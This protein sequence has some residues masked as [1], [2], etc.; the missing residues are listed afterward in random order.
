MDWSSKIKSWIKESE[1]SAFDKSLLLKQKRREAVRR[2][3]VFAISRSSVRMQ[4]YGIKT[5]A[6]DLTMAVWPQFVCT[7]MEIRPTERPLRGVHARL[8]KEHV[9]IPNIQPMPASLRIVGAT[10]HIHD[11]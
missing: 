1:V 11:F 6:P 10:L 3:L 4:C 5:D 9:Q 7:R 2:V 8:V